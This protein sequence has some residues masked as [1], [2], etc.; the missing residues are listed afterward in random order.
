MNIF[1]LIN[2]IYIIHETLILYLLLFLQ[3]KLIVKKEEP[4]DEESTNGIVG[5]KSK[6]SSHYALH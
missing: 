4:K 6:Y 2:K 5:T 1:N 3:G